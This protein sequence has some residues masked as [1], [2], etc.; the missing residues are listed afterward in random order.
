VLVL[1]AA[2]TVLYRPFIFE[3]GNIQAVAAA[4]EGS[5]LLYV[6][7][8][9]SRPIRAGLRRMR[10][11]PYVA[12]ALVY[13]GLAIFAFSSIANFGLLVRQ[14]VQLLPFMLVLLC[15]PSGQSPAWPPAPAR[16]AT[17]QRPAPRPLAA[18]RGRFGR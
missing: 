8:A 18:A 5:F 10:R 16:P 2:V 3:A 6:T 15:V 14:R 9:R 1:P 17:G 7:L 11:T 13:T 4:V 12:F